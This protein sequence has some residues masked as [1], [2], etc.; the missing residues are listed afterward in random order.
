[1][2]PRYGGGAIGGAIHHD[3]FHVKIGVL[4]LRLKRVQAKANSLTRA[5]RWDN[6][7]YGKRCH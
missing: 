4:S 2:R 1:V 7:C 6:D 5:V 3:R